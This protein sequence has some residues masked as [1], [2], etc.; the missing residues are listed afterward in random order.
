MGAETKSGSKR[1]SLLYCSMRSICCRGQGVLPELCWGD[2]EI[3]AT[4]YPH[5][6][7]CLGRGPSLGVGSDRR[8]NESGKGRI[9]R[10]TASH[11]S[12]GVA[13]FPGSRA[14]SILGFMAGRGELVY[15]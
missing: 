5:S 9:F 8:E 10:T 12:R 1:R 15:G 2:L 14:S 6:V 4:R 7:L 3:W 13:T 11:R